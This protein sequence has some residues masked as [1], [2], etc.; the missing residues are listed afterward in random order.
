MNLNSKH[1]IRLSRVF[2]SESDSG[3]IAKKKQ[4][5]LGCIV[6]ATLIS[7]LFFPQTVK[8]NII[9]FMSLLILYLPFFIISQL[10]LTYYFPTKYQQGI[11]KHTYFIK[12]FFATDARLKQPVYV[13]IVQ[14]F[15]W[16]IISRY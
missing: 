8:L 9:M 10:H 13:C 3:E 14:R 7:L 15:V 11:K 12:I 2:F 6:I 16:G 5:T 4:A 1:L